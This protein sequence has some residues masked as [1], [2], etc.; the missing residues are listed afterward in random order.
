VRLRDA[1]RATAQAWLAKHYD[2]VGHEATLNLRAAY[3]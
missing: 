1:G 2:A 3:Q